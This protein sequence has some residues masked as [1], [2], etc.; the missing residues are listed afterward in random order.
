MVTE[1]GRTP[2]PLSQAIIGSW[3]LFFRE[4]RTESGA[5]HPDPNLGTEPAGLLVYDAGGRFSAQFMKRDRQ[6]GERPGFEP[7]RGSTN[8]SSAVGGY[9]AYFGRYTV[10]DDAGEVTQTLDGALAAADVGKVVIRRMVVTG[11]ELM[12]RLPTTAVDGT[13]VVRTLKWRRVA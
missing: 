6:P 12:L 5:V 13:P 8:N 1:D 7:G 3:E 10:A 2:R 11:D 4:D 9:D